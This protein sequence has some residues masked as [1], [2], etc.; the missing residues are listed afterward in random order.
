MTELRPANVIG[1]LRITRDRLA[2]RSLF[3]VLGTNLD[4]ADASLSSV[5]FALGPPR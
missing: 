5:G 2:P 1:V 3:S 4:R